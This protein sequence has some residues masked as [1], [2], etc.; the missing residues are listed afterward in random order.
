M[1]CCMNCL[2]VEFFT[3]N[4]PSGPQL[5]SFSTWESS[6]KDGFQFRIWSVLIS[7]NECNFSVTCDLL[8]QP[9]YQ[10]GEEARSVSLGLLFRLPSPRLG[11]HL[12][13]GREK[14]PPAFV[15]SFSTRREEEVVVV[16]V[17]VSF[18]CSTCSFTESFLSRF[19]LLLL[20]A[21]S[22]NFL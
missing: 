12:R 10:P 1:R 9:W 20:L 5:S 11:L 22:S 3:R 17:M 14:W 2:P 13:P 6:V 18:S 7:V 15:F 4:K 21:F 8:H 19:S 16:V